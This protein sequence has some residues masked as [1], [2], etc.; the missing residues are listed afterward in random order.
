MN[1]CKFKDLSK[2]LFEKWVEYN[3]DNC[4]HKSEINCIINKKK[5]ITNFT[6]VINEMF[7]DALNYY[8]N[9]DVILFINS[10]KKKIFNFYLNNLKNDITIYGIRDLTVSHK[11]LQGIIYQIFYERIKMKTIDDIND[12]IKNL[13]KQEKDKYHISLLVFKNNKHNIE[14]KLINNFIYYYP[15]NFIEKSVIASVLLQNKSLEFLSKID[16]NN[17]LTKFKKSKIY[18]LKYRK[19]LYENINIKY[20]HKFMLFSSICLYLLGIRDMNDLDLYIS[21]LNND[22]ENK[23]LDFVKNTKEGQYY[24]FIDISIKGTQYWKPYWNIWLTEW[25]RLCGTQSFNN[26]LVDSNYHFYWMGIKIISPECDI[27]RR[28]HRNRPRAYGDLIII[29]KEKLY[30]FDIPTPEFSKKDYKIIAN[31]TSNELNEHL[32]NGW[33]YKDKIEIYKETAIDK[34]K[35]ISTIVW[36]L[37]KMYKFEVTANDVKDMLHIKDID[38]NKLNNNVFT[39]EYREFRQKMY[40]IKQSIN[41]Y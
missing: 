13:I 27:K 14:Q 36:W 41:N 26:I 1:I 39:D 10:N 30:K 31:L 38:D 37:K 34:Y 32:N 19:Y 40:K 22:I 4:E 33:Q 29:K 16:I 18:F 3:Y 11:Q 12:I 5:L 35:F 28:I 25:A 9:L 7:I 8:D 17:I 15:T 20:H 6:S 2:P 21:G 23:I 24:E